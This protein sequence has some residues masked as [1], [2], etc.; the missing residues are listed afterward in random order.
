MQ[1]VLRHFGLKGT[2]KGNRQVN[3]PFHDD[4]SASASINFKKG[5]LHCF[6]CKKGWRIDE[7]DRH[8]A[9][10]QETH[11]EEPAVA[12]HADVAHYAG[13]TDEELGT[14]AED[15]LKQRGVLEAAEAAP[16]EVNVG[17]DRDD[18]H[19]GYL[20]FRFPGGKMVARDLLDR[21]KDRRYLNSKGDKGLAWVTEA[22]EKQEPVWLTEGIF[23]ALS[24]ATV[25]VERVAAVLGS[26]LSDAQAYDLRHRTVFLAFDADAA[27]FR[28]A[29]EAAKLL[30]EFEATPI[31]LEF[32]RDLGKDFNELL[33]RDRKE[34][35][36]W[37]QQ[38]RMEF[39]R[40]DKDYLLRM[41]EETESLQIVSTG[42]E[43]Y[44]ALLGGGYRSG[45]HAIGAEP[46]VG[47]T[48]WALNVAIRAV[49]EQGKR[50]LV[51][52]YEISKRQNWA[53]IASYYDKAPWEQIELDPRTVS[54]ATK[55][56]VLQLGEHLRIMPGWKVEKIQH[57]AKDFD[58]IIVDYL[59]RMPGPFGANE[60]RFNVNYN[61]DR[62]SD[63]AR[64]FDKV[65]I[66]IS[67]LPRSDYGRITKKSFKESGNI[68]YVSQ[69]LTGFQPS[70]N[71][72]ITATVV[73][74]TRGREGTFFMQT[75]L[76]H[77]KFSYSKP[78][79]AKR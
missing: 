36:R 30:S 12:E 61:V 40:S 23:D 49:E 18:K 79:G 34:L 76:G 57:A 47:K 51:V 8:L 3:C 14:L 37:V 25:G 21:G 26:E 71:G 38:Q 74:N 46:G 13:L 45:L 42:I 70:G 4:S 56:K 7:V 52:P 15:Y 2:E 54:P 67:S 1:H 35:A 66:A 32:P 78:P 20:V 75:D 41:Y 31:I 60:S 22:G 72:A 9:A 29:K 5:V 24:L 6:T 11:Q 27:G 19:F 65:V 63:L 69:T 17:T 48:A 64:D 39:G 44:D 58:V 53:R 50:V 62:L 59:Q 33:V 68:E 55:R 43:G 77:I 28:G 10:G 16:L 73:K